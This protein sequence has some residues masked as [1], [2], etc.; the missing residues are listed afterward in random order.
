MIVS[1]WYVNC[2][3]SYELSMGAERWLSYRKLPKYIVYF[4]YSLVCHLPSTPKDRNTVLFKIT[5]R[6]NIMRRVCVSIWEWSN[7]LFIIFY[8]SFSFDTIFSYYWPDDCQNWPD[9]P[10]IVHMVRDMR[11]PEGLG[12]HRD[13]TLHGTDQE[14]RRPQSET[15][16]RAH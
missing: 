5:I 14:Q 12:S 8:L 2:Y 9:F 3:K 16:S 15:D 7:H 4:T 6:W 10:R 11:G 1:I 13:I